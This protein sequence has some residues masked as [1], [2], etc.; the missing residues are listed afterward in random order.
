MSPCIQF[1]LNRLSVWGVVELEGDA[2]RVRLTRDEWGRL[3]L[4]VGHRVLFCLRRATRDWLYV[5]AVDEQ[6]AFVWL[7][8]TDQSPADARSV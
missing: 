5:S 3:H 6:P 4:G 8:L 1:N 7:M 2:V